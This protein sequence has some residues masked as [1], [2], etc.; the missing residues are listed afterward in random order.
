MIC[1]ACLSIYVFLYMLPLPITKNLSITLLLSR[2][3][4]VNY[5]LCLYCNS[6]VPILVLLVNPH[7]LV[8][9]S[10]TAFIPR[11]LLWT[12]WTLSDLA[13]FYFYLILT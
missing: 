9:D 11:A 12:S 5:Q 13:Y 4:T 1:F 10:K 7:N 6:I 3:L 2:V 8:Q